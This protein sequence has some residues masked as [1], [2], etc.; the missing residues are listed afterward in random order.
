MS[1]AELLESPEVRAQVS[2]ISV[3]EYHQFP[4]F[5]QNGR[6]TELVRGIVLEKMPKTPSHASIATL[7]YNTVHALAPEG[8]WVRAD[9]PMT[10]RESEPEPD[11]ALVR[12]TGDEYWTAHPVTAVLVIEVAVT[13]GRLDR[14]KATI[15][16]EAGVEEYWIV[17][18]RERRVEVYR[19]PSHGRY[20]ENIPYETGLLA[21]QRVPQIAID[22]NAL[23]A[24]L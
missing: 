2:P 16:A 11:I 17:L 14:E 4:E 9:Q 20:E 7:L 10:L 24:R 12:G 18:P 1:P 22:L 6:R 8:F 5:N 23:F 21:C 13:S 19:R 15:Y 3:E